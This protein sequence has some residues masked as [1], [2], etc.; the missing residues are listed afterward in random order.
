LFTMDKKRFIFESKLPQVAI[1]KQANSQE[2]PT[3]LLF[4]RLKNPEIYKQ[5]TKLYEEYY[6]HIDYHN[7]TSHSLKYLIEFNL[8]KRIKAVESDTP[9]ELDPEGEG[10]HGGNNF[11]LIQWSDISRESIQIPFAFDD[12]RIDSSKL[13]QIQS[14]IESHEKGHVVRS[15]EDKFFRDYFAGGFDLNAKIQYQDYIWAGASYRYKDG[16]AAMVGINL[17]N[18][19]NIGYSYDLT[20]SR[21]NTVSKGTHE[22]VL[23]FILGNKYGDWCPRYNF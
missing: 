5:L 23:G 12:S 19:I 22:F 20:T 13:I 8:N 2:H 11:G 3:L 7:H 6:N 1:E 21:L 14:I 10:S 17:S 18:S 9:I 16:Y 4:S 15:F